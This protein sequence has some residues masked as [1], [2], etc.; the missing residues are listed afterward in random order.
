[1]SMSKVETVVLG[2]LAEEPMHGYQ[3]FERLRGRSPGLG[4]DVGR[5]S[6][7]QGLARLSERGS[8]SG[9]WRAGA[10]GPARRVY[11]ITPK[12]R[13]RLGAALLQQLQESS[14][15]ESAGGLALGFAH[16]LAPPDARRAVDARERAV[17]ALIDEVR[18]RR[19]AAAVDPASSIRSAM[20]DRQE[21][22]ARAELGW[23]RSLR[24]AI[25]AV[26]PKGS[27]TGTPAP[28]VSL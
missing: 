13:A 12:G 6:V 25:T 1:M 28:T 19:S 26:R 5:A 20:L 17:R 4:H 24:T 23:L 15:Y 11:R 18:S 3:L 2:L 8:V 7:Y 10:G 14:P 16:L 27:R 22:L 21:A 9:S